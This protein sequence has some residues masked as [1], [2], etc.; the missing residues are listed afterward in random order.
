MVLERAF[1]IPGEKESLEENNAAFVVCQCLM[2]GTCMNAG[3]DRAD[4]TVAAEYN[5]VRHSGLRP[6]HHS[7]AQQESVSS[8]SSCCA[9]RLFFIN[10]ES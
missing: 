4:K 1:T 6:G 9:G 2:V 10:K 8:P 5:K 3:R 7:P